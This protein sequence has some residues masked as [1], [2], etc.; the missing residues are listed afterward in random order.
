[1][2]GSSRDIGAATAF[3]RVSLGGTGFTVVFGGVDVLVFGLAL[4]LTFKGLLATD[5]PA[6]ERARAA[7]FSARLAIGKVLTFFLRAGAALAT[8]FERFVATFFELD[9]LL[10]AR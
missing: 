9:F 2:T 1:M 8:D 6:I 10:P 5:E 4:A 3:G 7:V